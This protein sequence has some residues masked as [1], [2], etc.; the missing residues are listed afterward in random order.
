MSDPIS[1]TNE[2]A[3]WAALVADLHMPYFDGEG[4]YLGESIMLRDL[5]RVIAAAQAQVLHDAGAKVG[6]MRHTISGRRVA[7]ADWLGQVVYA[8]G[9]DVE[10][11]AERLL[12]PGEAGPDA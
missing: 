10:Y 7:N 1:L 6:R 8:M 9:D 12:R 4:D 11:Q 3:A 5:P 2:Q